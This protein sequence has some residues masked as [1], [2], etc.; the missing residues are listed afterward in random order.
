MRRLIR[1]I[2]PLLVLLAA[3]S[4]VLAE[5]FFAVCESEES[6]WVSP[7]DAEVEADDDDDNEKEESLVALFATP[8]TVEFVE[9]SRS[10]NALNTATML[11][12]GQDVRGSPAVR[13]L[14]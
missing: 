8:L 13:R 1:D 7:G 5:P 4:S 6:L 9:R 12:R 3:A 14:A 10:A 11:R 2:L